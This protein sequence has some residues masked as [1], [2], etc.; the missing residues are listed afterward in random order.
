LPPRLPRNFHWSGR[1]VVP[2]LNITVPFVWNG[3]NGDTQMI[4]GDINYPIW[5][6]NFIIKNC[7]YTYTFK[8]PGLTH[9]FLPGCSKCE[10]LPFSLYID[11]LNT[12]LASSSFVC[13]E[14]L[15]VDHKCIKVNHFRLSIVLQ[16]LNPGPGAYPRLPITSAD[17]Y[18]ERTDSTRFVKILHFGLQNLYDPN[19]DEWIILDNLEDCP[20]DICIPNICKPCPN[21][22]C[23]SSDNSPYLSSINPVDI[24]SLT[25]NLTP[26]LQSFYPIKL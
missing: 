6:T 14:I 5:F 4:A 2:D 20:G 19:L 9:Q 23:P 17:I 3:R 25:V 24:K 11:D 16:L 18:V 10:P 8:W 7:I 1:Y 22:P 26:F 21:P 13:P 12:L 15:E